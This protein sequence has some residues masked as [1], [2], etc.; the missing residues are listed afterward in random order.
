MATRVVEGKKPY[1][2]WKAIDVNE[3]KV[4]SLK[5]R[6]ENNLIIYDEWDDE[7]YV[8]L[9][10]DDELEPTDAFPVW[11]NTGRVIVDNGW[12]KTGTIIIAKTTSGDYIQLLYAD[13]GTL[14]MDNGTG[15][16][17]QILFKWDID[18][19]VTNLTNYVDWELA[20]KQDLTVV[21]STAP[22][23]PTE[24][25]LWYDTSSN[26]LYIYD[27]TT[28]QSTWSGWGWGDVLVS[29]QANNIFTPWMKIWGWTKSDFDDLV[30]DSNTAYLILADQPSPPSPWWQPWVNT[31]AYWK[32]DWDLTD[33]M[34]SYDGSVV[35]ATI[36]YE[37]LP[38]DNTKQCAK[39]NSSSFD[40]GIG[41][42]SSI[43]NEILS[44]NIDFTFWGFVKTTAGNAEM[45]Y[46]EWGNSTGLN[47]SERVGNFYIEPFG[48]GS[49]SYTANLSSNT[50]YSLIFTYNSTTRTWSFYT[51]GVLTWTIT[52]SQ[53]YNTWTSPIKAFLARIN[54]DTLMS[55]MVLEKN[56]AWDSTTVQSFHDTFK[57]L[58]G[59]S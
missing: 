31:V 48:Q 15:T 46:M 43:N 51:N 30:E 44:S 34:W 57:S 40:G 56:V 38:W 21:D 37:T 41:L 8:D 11:V 7:I 20:N 6:D 36:T 25:L 26:T 33:E 16:F 4:I 5:L 22:A 14:W 49:E 47:F 23:D 45:L 54:T 29:T 10:L 53:D 58:Y 50:W 35:S 3:D 13:D 32:L 27:G 2:W 12:D 42:S 9:Q 59:L 17:K 55:N 24:W 39:V 19:I 18:T 1:T 28:W 52:K